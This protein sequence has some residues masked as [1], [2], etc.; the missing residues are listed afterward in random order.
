[1]E[2]QEFQLQTQLLRWSDS[3][4]TFIRRRVPRKLRAAISTDEV[5]QEV[6]IIAHRQLPRHL[7]GDDHAVLRWLVVVARRTLGHAI[8]RACCKKRGSDFRRVIN[9]YPNTSC[10]DLLGRLRDEKCRTPSRENA[11]E[12][13]AHEVRVALAT[14]PDEQLHAICMRHFEGRSHDEIAKTLGKSRSAVNSLLHRGMG[15]LRKVLGDGSRF[16]S[17]D[18]VVRGGVTQQRSNSR[19]GAYVE[20]VPQDQDNPKTVRT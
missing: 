17:D 1:M 19:R 12:E 7:V 9:D 5:R 11:A 18:W 10:V 13:A 4:S 14:L 3:L 6:W 2:T 16:F 20:T 8:A 15:N